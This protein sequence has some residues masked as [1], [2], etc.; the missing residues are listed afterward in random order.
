MDTESLGQLWNFSTLSELSQVPY[1]QT[2]QAINQTV[3]WIYHASLSPGNQ[4]RIGSAQPGKLPI[5]ASRNFRERSSEARAVSIT[6]L[7]S[8]ENSVGGA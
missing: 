5:T 8:G 3:K 6:C 4:S 1:I 2:L 7:I